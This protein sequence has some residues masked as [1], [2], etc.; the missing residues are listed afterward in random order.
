MIG[1]YAHMELCLAGAGLARE[2]YEAPFEHIERVEHGLGLAA[3]HGRTLA[4]LFEWARFAHHPCGIEM[5]HSALSAVRV[6]QEHLEPAP[7]GGPLQA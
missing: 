1:A 4:G 5:K 7:A 3:G 2:P 6:V